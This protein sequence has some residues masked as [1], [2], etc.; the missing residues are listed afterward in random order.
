MMVRIT[1]ERARRFPPLIPNDETI[2]AIKAAR[3]GELET[4]DSPQNLV[5]RLN[6]ADE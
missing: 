4:A 5:D 1:K 6:A 3:R 2:E